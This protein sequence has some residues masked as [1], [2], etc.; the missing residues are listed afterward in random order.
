MVGEKG[1]RGG[2]RLRAVFCEKG[3]VRTKKGWILRLV[4][5]YVYM[6]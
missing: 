3:D 5:M 4:A 6:V 2:G 1:E